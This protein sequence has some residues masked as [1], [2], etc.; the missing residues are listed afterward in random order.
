ML[1]RLGFQPLVEKTL[2]VK[3]L[4]PAMTIYQ[5][6]L[7]MV[8]AAHVGFSRLYHLRFVAR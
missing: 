4:P 7:A 6:V 5:F 1:E 8:L 3:R 2:T